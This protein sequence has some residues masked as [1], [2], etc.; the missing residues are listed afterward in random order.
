MPETKIHRGF[1]T[2]IAWNKLWRKENPGCSARSCT[3]AHNIWSRMRRQ[4]TSIRVHGVR[5]CVPECLEGALHAAIKTAGSVAQPNPA[6]HR[7]P[8]GLVL[9]SRQ[10]LTAP[11]L[12]SALD[13]QRSAG[14]GRIGEW[15]QDMGFADERQITAA[16][17]RQWSC[18]ILQTNT[19]VLNP[20]VLPQI[21]LLL[22]GLFQMIPISFVAATAMLHVAFADGID[23]SVLYAIERMLDCRTQPCVVLPSLLR[24]SLSALGER[25]SATEFVFDR[26]SDISELV[27]IVSNYA[28]RVSAREIRLAFCGPYSWVRLECASGQTLDL[29]LRMP[30][31]SHS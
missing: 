13:A 29:L 10:Q 3:H 26:V 25:R 27:G 24:E 18:P 5:Y 9:L 30:R 2:G 20:V 11:Q 15:L 22:L 28:V 23:Y 17:A 12:R 6:G 14:R 21:P 4:Q 1:W 16:L 8:L 7:I 31:H 19:P